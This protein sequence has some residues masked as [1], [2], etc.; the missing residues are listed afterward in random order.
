M[1]SN[2]TINRKKKQPRNLSYIKN[3]VGRV[4]YKEYS[5]VLDDDCLL[6]Q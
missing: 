4:Q 5:R 2:F 6:C 3:D 1:I